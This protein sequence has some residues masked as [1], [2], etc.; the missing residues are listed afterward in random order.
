MKIL[1]WEGLTM[2]KIFFI[3]AFIIS[4]SFNSYP[5]E[6]IRKI[7]T[8]N[9]KWLGTN[10]GNQ[11]DALE[12]IEHYADYILITGAT[13]FAL[14]EIGP[15]HSVAGEPKCFYLDKI[16]DELNQSIPGELERWTYVLDNS[17]KQQ[18]LAFLFKKNLWELSN[19]RI[20]SPGSSFNYIRKPFLVTVKAKGDNAELEFNFINIHLKA[21]DDAGSR[22]T[23]KNNFTQLSAWLQNNTLDEDVLIGGDTN[24][25]FGETDAY[26][27]MSDINYKYLYDAERTSVYS[28]LLGER[29][30]RFFSSA[31]IN[32]EIESAKNIVGSGNYID[33]IKDSDPEEIIWFS[34]NISDHFAVVLNIDVSR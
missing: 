33:V 32:N 24:I 11:L 9:M 34:Q 20:I 13:L 2:K 30:D 26:Q 27:S 5:Q 21:F 8:W 4:F 15:T 10:S 29:F 23:R 31:G 16:V 25:Y 18:R 6:N 17:N 1:I 3:S 14:Q 7:A 22:T 28:D 12:N 19:F